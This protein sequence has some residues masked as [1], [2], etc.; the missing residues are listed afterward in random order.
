MSGVSTGREYIFLSTRH[1]LSDSDAAT[2]DSIVR[3]VGGYGFVGPLDAGPVRGYCS[4]PCHGHDANRVMH[5][6]VARTLYALGLGHLFGLC[7][8]GR[9]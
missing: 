7:P 5:D 3:E 2:V 4:A 8:P 6:A 9:P 1:V